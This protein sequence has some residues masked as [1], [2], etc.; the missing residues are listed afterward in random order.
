MSFRHEH[1]LDR[2]CPALRR[3]AAT[4]TAL[5]RRLSRRSALSGGGRGLIGAYA[6]DR[7]VGSYTTL[8]ASVN[9]DFTPDFS[10]SFMVT[11]LG[12]RMP[13]MDQT[14]GGLTGQPYAI[15]NYDVY[16]RGYFLEA[17]YV[18]NRD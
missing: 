6:R 12:N 11:N 14:Y 1:D 16:G 17:R 8:N 3:S 5:T 4:A 7:G 15:N 9:Y 13:D 18:F 10:M 2:T